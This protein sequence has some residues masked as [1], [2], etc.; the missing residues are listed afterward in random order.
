[1]GK[2]HADEHFSGCAGED[3]ALPGDPWSRLRY[4]YGQLLGADDFQAEQNAVVLRR[5]LHN[6]LLH[7]LGTVCGLRVSAAPGDPPQT[8][9]EVAQGL[10]VDVYGREIYVDESQC[11]DVIGLHG[12]DFWATLARSPAVADE[13]PPVTDMRRAYVTLCY[14]ACLSNQV[15]A[16][17]PPCGDASEALAFSRV[18]DRFRIDLAAEQPPDPHALQGPGWP[19]VAD[20]ASGDLRQWLLASLLDYPGDG[21]ELAHLWTGSE[22][23]P[24]LLAVVDL[25]HEDSGAGE[26]TRVEL[27]DNS[28]RALL[29]AAQLCAEQ[30][31]RQRLA[32]AAAD[33][34]LKLLTIEDNS[35]AADA[36]TAPAY[37]LRFSADLEAGTADGD[38]VR[39]YALQAGVWTITG[40]CCSC[41]G[42]IEARPIPC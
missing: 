10:A 11:L 38:S 33:S 13:D 16:I 29:P 26:L 30:S 34:A 25:V 19:P 36:T 8:R 39:A 35:A 12:S 32:G 6:A 24:L 9:L 1:M 41:P 3:P 28:P 22:P 4:H 15:P 5:R 18:N 37:T 2:S 31:L 42:F 14:E 17:T 27:I 23:A 21:I 7:G 20:G 40:K